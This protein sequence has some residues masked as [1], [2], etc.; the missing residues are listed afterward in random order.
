M[1]EYNYSHRMISSSELARLCGV[2]QPTV[3]RALHN[4]GRIKKETREAILKMAEKHGYQAN[5]LADEIL[6]GKSNVVGAIT[7]FLNVPFFIAIFNEIA[8][9]LRSQGKSLYITMANTEAE[10]NQQLK[11]FKLRRIKDVL[12]VFPPHQTWDLD[13]VVIKGMKLYSLINPHSACQ[14]VLPDEIQCGTVGTQHLIDQGHKKIAYL[15]FEWNEW[16][17]EQRLLGY[18]KA[19]QDHHQPAHSIQLPDPSEKHKEFLKAL[20]SNIKKAIT[21]Y[22]ATAFFCHNDGL[23]QEVVRCLEMM[24]YKVP[25]NFS[26]LGVDAT[27]NMTQRMSSV[28]YPFNELAELCT[29]LITEKKIKMAALKPKFKILAGNSVRR[30]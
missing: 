14:N 3:H 1:L 8:Q 18:L 5:P 20:N 21:D 24:D 6:R 13:P 27:P 9:K 22:G 26:V 28:A 12:T 17:T 15:H 30:K 7:F 10:F 19:M 16:A 29:N 2:S 23:A 11:E 4:K 25:E